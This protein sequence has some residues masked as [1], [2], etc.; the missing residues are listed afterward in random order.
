MP[1]YRNVKIAQSTEEI[2]EEHLEEPLKTFDEV[3]DVENDNL[4]DVVV[5]PTKNIPLDCYPTYE[6]AYDLRN[7][8][9][10]PLGFMDMT[11]QITYSAF[12]DRFGVKPEI[13]TEKLDNNF[14]NGLNITKEELRNDKIE[15]LLNLI[16][17]L[18]KESS[19]NGKIKQQISEEFLERVSDKDLNECFENMD[20]CFEELNNS[21]FFN[22]KR[23]N[24]VVS[25]LSNYKQQYNNLYEQYANN[26]IAIQ[27]YGHSSH[28]YDYTTSHINE[29]VSCA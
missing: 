24:R 7:K 9:N 2:P 27:K 16:R 1:Y 8:D 5:I 28:K 13:V 22:E 11:K 10:L 23:F 17:I 19:R 12:E 29:M 3:Y 25:I 15:K 18:N 26:P 6:H 4:V 20:K 14:K 21:N